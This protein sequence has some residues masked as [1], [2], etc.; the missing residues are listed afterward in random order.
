MQKLNPSPG[1][2]SQ[3]SNGSADLNNDLLN[4]LPGLLEQDSPDQRN[5]TGTSESS[6]ASPPKPRQDKY[7]K[8]ER[9]LS[10]QFGM[11][12]MALMLLQPLDGQTILEHAEPLAKQ[13]ISVSRQNEQF[14]QFLKRLVD[15]GLYAGLATECAVIVIALLKNHGVDIPEKIREMRRSK[16]A[17]S[18]LIDPVAA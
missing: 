7:G 4:S 9:Q 16:N 11:L 5:G 2:S 18:Q 17:D 3:S 8:L 6:T 12:G 13:L 10:E 1:E 15:G 14:Y